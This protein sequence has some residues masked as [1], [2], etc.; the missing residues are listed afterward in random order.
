MTTSTSTP[1][2]RPGA[3]GDHDLVVRDL[4][5]EYESGGY[6]L[7]VLDEL[8]FVARPGE[9]VVL[10][11]PSGSGKTTLLSCIGGMLTPTSGSVTVGGREVTSLGGAELDAYR[12][13]DVGFVFQG[14]N[15]LGSLTARENVAMPLLVTRAASRREAMARATELLEL[16]GLADRMDHRP[17]HL[18]GGQQQRV[19]VA[20]GLVTDPVLLLA[21][22]P[23]ANLDHIQAQSVIR[24]LTELRD[25][26]R[27]IVVSSHDA[28]LMPAADRVVQMSGEAD[29]VEAGATV[30]SY[31]DGEVVFHQN[32]HASLV[33]V[34]EEG[35]AEVYREL[36]DGGEESLAV[37]GPGQYFG[38][39]GAMLGFPRSASVRAVGE[40]RLTS[41]SPHGFRMLLERGGGVA[42]GDGPPTADR[43]LPGHPSDAGPTGPR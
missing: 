7:R 13:R 10:L 28:R 33:F 4:V 43:R 32:D 16:V 35:E 9:L 26:G 34:I 14:F 8:S 5:K 21:D 22:E 20:R 2:E 24:L 17:S 38:E 39:L 31:A 11:G 36:A 41:H 23:T 30:V 25:E 1:V 40:L 19:A 18:S 42:G 12:R 27:I 29:P 6:R 3:T 37:L 15:L